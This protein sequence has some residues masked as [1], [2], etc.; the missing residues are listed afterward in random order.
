MLRKLSNQLGTLRLLVQA[1]ADLPALPLALDLAEALADGRLVAVVAA[2]QPLAVEPSR[3]IEELVNARGEPTR[4]L[5]ELT[6]LFVE[7]DPTKVGAVVVADTSMLYRAT[8]CATRRASERL[9]LSSG[10][11]DEI[12]ESAISATEALGR[13]GIHVIWIA[14]STRDRGMNDDGDEVLLS[15]SSPKCWGDLP[16]QV[17]LWLEL[18]RGSTSC[19]VRRDAIGL[20]RERIEASREGLLAPL[21]GRLGMRPRALTTTL[22]ESNAREL[23]ARR[24]RELARSQLQ[25]KVAARITALANLRAQQGPDR[26]A[27]LMHE[28]EGLRFEVAPEFAKQVDDQL[29]GRARASA[30]AWAMIQR[31]ENTAERTNHDPE[32]ALSLELAGPHPDQV[33]SVDVV[34]I[35][36]VLAAEGSFEGW[37]RERIIAAIE[38]CARSLG[39]WSRPRLAVIAACVGVGTRGLSWGTYENDALHRLLLGLASMAAT[40]AA[41]AEPPQPS[42]VV[43]LPRR[44][45]IREATPGLV[46]ELPTPET[47]ASLDRRHACDYLCA[48]LTAGGH[49][50]ELAELQEQAGLATRTK[51][52]RAWSDAERSAVYGLA[53]RRRGLAPDLPERAAA[54]R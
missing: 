26:W 19:V 6:E 38:A 10:L 32:Q 24:R 46:L 35:D 25:A 31:F 36:E 52:V 7:L 33:P 14:P 39:V 48:V 9:E 45:E 2:G 18:E 49:W 4:S 23:E 12:A 41:Y 27:E 40:E 54:R 21:R 34:R 50:S 43:E 44:A 22:D 47:L 5:A 29:A 11:W 8:R 17:H 16:R 53:L 28:W 37:S 42:N 51:D 13:R 30:G 1:E 20:G 15:T 3:P